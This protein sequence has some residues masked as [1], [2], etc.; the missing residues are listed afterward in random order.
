MLTWQ[1]THSDSISLTAFRNIMVAV[2]LAIALIVLAMSLALSAAET[3]D[4]RDVLVS[5]GAR[6]STMRSLSA[7]KAALLAVTAALIAIPTGF[8][9]VAVV[10]YAVVRAGEAARLSFPLSTVVVLVVA[11]P[12]IAAIVAYVGGAIAQTV[13][14][15]KMSTFATD[16]V[17]RAG[18]R[19]RFH[20]ATA[21]PCARLDRPK[22]SL[23]AERS[24]AINQ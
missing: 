10:F 18:R 24:E 11:A 12:L 20:A 17:R 14:P 16:L 1:G 5:L 23:A 13:R 21:Q 6:P 9:P 19:S 4:E 3:R 2:V 15:T 8:V 7:W 22:R